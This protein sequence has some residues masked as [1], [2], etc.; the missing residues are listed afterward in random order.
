MAE[1]NQ[2]CFRTLHHEKPWSMDAYL[3]VG[4][5]QVWKKILAEKT[6]PEKIL[7]A[8]KLSALRGRGGAGFPSGLKDRKSVV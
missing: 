6:P 3:S 2:V 1:H 5:Y 4:G 8:L 7:E